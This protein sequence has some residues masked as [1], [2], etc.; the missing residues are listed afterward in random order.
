MSF[1]QKKRLRKL[2]KVRKVRKTFTNTKRPIVR[3]LAFYVWI[4][5][6]FKIF[7]LNTIN[8]KIYGSTN[9]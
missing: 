9:Y 4:F 5:C 8:S 2:R 3:F 7:K 6:K 1:A